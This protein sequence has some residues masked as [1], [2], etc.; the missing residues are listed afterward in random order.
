MRMAWHGI[1]A[2]KQHWGPEVIADGENIDQDET[3]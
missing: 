1:D 2:L 3:E